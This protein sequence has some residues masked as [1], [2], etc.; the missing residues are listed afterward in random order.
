MHK[1]TV[2]KAS[3]DLAH[4]LCR[5]I[6]SQIDSNYFSKEDI[7]NIKLAIEEAMINAVEHGNKLE[8][9]K[10]IAVDYSITSDAFEISITDE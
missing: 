10:D 2:I 9:L 7:F 4:K 5:E 3:S 6:A 8:S 1:T